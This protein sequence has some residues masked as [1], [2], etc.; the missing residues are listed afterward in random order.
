MPTLADGE[1]KLLLTPSARG[2]IP[3]NIW[4]RAHVVY[5]DDL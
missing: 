5:F 4:R 2:S 3:A 1:Y